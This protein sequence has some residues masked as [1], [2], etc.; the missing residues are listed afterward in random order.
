MALLCISSPA[1]WSH[2]T[3]RFVIPAG[4][5]GRNSAWCP[6]GRPTSLP[7]LAWVILPQSGGLSSRALQLHSPPAPAVCSHCGCALA[8]RVARAHAPWRGMNWQ[9][10]AC[11]QAALTLLPWHHVQTSWGDVIFPKAGALGA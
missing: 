9:E 10:A 4:I 7:T 6:Q 5:D 2:N 8:G 1:W 11:G 3:Q